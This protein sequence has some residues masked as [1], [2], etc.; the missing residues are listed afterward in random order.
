[1][2]GSHSDRTYEAGAS[3]QRPVLLCD[4]ALPQG[5]EWGRKHVPSSWSGSVLWVSSYLEL[6]CPTRSQRSLESP[7]FVSYLFST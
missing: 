3:I 5:C 2:R 4:L 6:L 1:M 7:A